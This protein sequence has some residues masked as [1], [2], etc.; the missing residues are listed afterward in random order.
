MA[1]SRRGQSKTSPPKES[2]ALKEESE[3]EASPEFKSHGS[4]LVAAE[5]L[6]DMATTEMY[7]CCW[8]QPPPSPWRD[9]S[10]VQEDTVAGELSQSC[11]HA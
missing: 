5:E 2:Q 3:D 10:P 6:P 4:S 7:L 8:H 9:P 11:K 1:R